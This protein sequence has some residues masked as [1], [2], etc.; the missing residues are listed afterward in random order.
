MDVMFK[1]FCLWVVGWIVGKEDVVLGRLL[2]IR[3]RRKSTCNNT[4]MEH[5]INLS[6]HHLNENS[7][8]LSFS[9]PNHIVWPTC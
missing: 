7:H 9:C 4:K 1:L 3:F 6:L 5:T 2:G 8:P